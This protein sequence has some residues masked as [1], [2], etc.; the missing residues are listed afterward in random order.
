MSPIPTGPD[1]GVYIDLNYDIF[2]PKYSEKFPFYPRF[3]T[4][5]PLNSRFSLWISIF[6]PQLNNNSYFCP[7]NQ[8]SKSKIYTPGRILKA[9]DVFWMFFLFN[10]N[11]QLKAK[12]WGS[13]L[14]V[15]TP[16]PKLG[17]IEFRTY[18]EFVAAVGMLRKN[19]IDIH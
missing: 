16:C 7:Q 4:T 17:I 5:S 6:F 19:K 13:M 2:A 18:T 10:K 14:S 12:K 3:Y 15:R 8:K 11:V 1:P 9:C